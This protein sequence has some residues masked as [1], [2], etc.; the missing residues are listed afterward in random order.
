MEKEELKEVIDKA[1]LNPMTETPMATQTDPVRNSVKAFIKKL[2]RIVG[3]ID[4]QK[5]NLDKE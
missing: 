4:K 1:M 3:K 2:E 5:E